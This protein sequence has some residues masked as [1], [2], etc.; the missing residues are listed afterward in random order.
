MRSKYR[1]YL[2]YWKVDHLYF[3]FNKP[4][5]PQR[6][7]ISGPRLATTLERVQLPQLRVNTKVCSF[8][9]CGTKKYRIELAESIFITILD[10][11]FVFNSLISIPF[12]CST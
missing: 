6:E 8:Y 1:D 9:L 3:F 7:Q 5:L 11:E 10:N 4:D 2:I 12:D